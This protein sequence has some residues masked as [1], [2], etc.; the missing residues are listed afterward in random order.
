MNLNGI[1]KIGTHKI[2][3][4][5]QSPI[6]FFYFEERE[7]I[8]VY[9]ANTDCYGSYYNWDSFTKMYRREGENLNLTKNDH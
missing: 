9:N 3:K 6:Q 8:V 2:A 5:G 7:S 1:T 4:Q